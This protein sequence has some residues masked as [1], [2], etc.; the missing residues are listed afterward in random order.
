MTDSNIY[1]SPSSDLEQTSEQQY[2]YAGFWIRVVASII[3]TLIVMFITIPLLLLVYGKSYWMSESFV[4]GPVDF[5][6]SYVFPAVAVI[7]F[8][9][10]KSATPGKMILNL[11][12]VDAKDFSTLKVSKAIIRYVGYYVSVIPL[13]LG[14]IWVGI[15]KKKQGFHDKMAGSVVIKTK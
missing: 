8:W 15:D 6:V 5:I 2:E 14:L 3:D 10:Y 13:M 7:L 9:I 1:Q 11:K 12:V 4:N